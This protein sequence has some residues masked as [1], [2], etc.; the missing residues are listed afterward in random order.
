MRQAEATCTRRVAFVRGMCYHIRSSRKERWGRGVPVISAQHLRAA[1]FPAAASA[2]LLCLCV[3]EDETAALRAALDDAP[4]HTLICVHGFDWERDL[5]PWP[6]PPLG[7]G[8]PFAGGAGECLP[9]LTEAILPKAEA[10]LPAPPAWR[11]I[12]GY[13][14]A[15]LFALWALGQTDIFSRAASMSGSLWY[16]GLHAYLSTHTPPRR[17]ECIYLSLGDREARARD[18]ALKTVRRATEAVA[19]HFRAQNIPTALEFPPG[20]HFQNVTERMAAGL[21]WLLER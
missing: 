7:R 8:R 2:P 18:P 1:V 17:P 9:L 12:A 4:A 15:G 21:R 13:S 3:A 5:S 10:L 6:A 16:P 11:A 20:N 14:L 19:A